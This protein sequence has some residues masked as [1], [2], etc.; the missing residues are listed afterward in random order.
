MIRCSEI[1]TSA[2]APDQEPAMPAR[3]Q[4]AIPIHEGDHDNRVGVGEPFYEFDQSENVILD[5]VHLTRGMTTYTIPADR[6]SQILAA[7]ELGSTAPSIRLLETKVSWRNRFSEKIASFLKQH[8]EVSNFLNLVEPKVVSVFGVCS[9]RLEIVSYSEVGA[10]DEL[11][12]KILCSGDWELEL[13][14]LEQLDEK[15]SQWPKE[16]GR[17]FKF[18]IE[19]E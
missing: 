6:E 1:E 10:Y 3:V 9:I 19:F 12:A 16:V 11:S 7:G 5:N 2:T 15:I 17:Y 14:K 13:E 4:R 18:D 8:E